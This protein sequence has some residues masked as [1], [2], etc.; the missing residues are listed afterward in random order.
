MQR[1]TSTRILASVLAL[2]VAFA[3][4]AEWNRGVQA[5]KKRDWKTA[6]K[7]FA[8]VVKT[9]P[10]YAGGYYMLGLVQLR[11]GKTSQA[12]GNL[13]KAVELD[14]GNVGAKVFL[15]QALLQGGQPGEAYTVLRKL[16]L[17]KVPAAQRSTYALLLASAASKLNRSREVLDTIAAQARRDPKNPRLQL[18]LGVAYSELGRDRDAYRAFRRA[19]E[20]DRKNTKAARSA[21]GAAI[22][23]ARRTRDAAAK[24]RL[25]SEA[26]QIATAVAR[27]R[28]SFDNL[29]LA[30]ETYLGAK[31]YASALSWFQ[32]AKAKKPNVALVHFYIG[33]CYSST[34]KFEASLAALQKALRLGPDSRLRKKIYNQ[35]GYVY[36]KKK[37]FDRAI[38]AYQNAGNASKVAEMRENKKKQEQNLKAQRER[39]EIRRKIR[40]L[41]A[42]IKELEQLGLSEEASQL[43]QQV[44]EAKKQ[45][46]AQ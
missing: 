7:E 9:N 44:D 27:S 18:A 35:M 14:P 5:Y 10:D 46:G 21:V 40:E 23:A 32:K 6:E 36:A 8:E 43:R 41:E 12:A 34:G 3:A 15:G 37:D 24:K 33:Q 38:T 39:E 31:D 30:G 19:W 2:V 45:L 28:P 4:A 29:L 13:R 16:E 22:R 1:T 26:A 20:L 25:Y 42:K 11:L 17:A